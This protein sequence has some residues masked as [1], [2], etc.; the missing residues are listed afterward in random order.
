MEERHEEMNE[1]RYKFIE[2]MDSVNEN[3][4]N[5]LGKGGW[6]VSSIVRSGRFITVVMEKKFIVFDDIDNRKSMPVARTISDPE[7]L[8]VCEKTV[9]RYD[10]SNVRTST[11]FI[12]IDEFKANEFYSDDG[13]YEAYLSDGFYFIGTDISSMTDDELD[14]FIKKNS[15][16]FRDGSE[17]KVYYIDYP[18]DK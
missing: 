9:K 18:E 7:A 13:E 1:Y 10:F 16:K 11:E 17:I 6:K 8:Y 2:F 3:D 5:D 15:N 4:I 12:S 14:E